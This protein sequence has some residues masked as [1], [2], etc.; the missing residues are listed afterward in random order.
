MTARSPDSLLTALGAGALAGASVGFIE[1][2]AGLI[3][4]G[5][6][7]GVPQISALV[8]E[9]PALGF[10]G[11]AMGTGLNLVARASRGL[12]P[13]FARIMFAAAL[14]LVPAI[15]LGWMGAP[16]GAA[17]VASAYWLWR[18]PDPHGLTILILWALLFIALH[19]LFGGAALRLVYTIPQQMTII[20][21]TMAAGGALAWLAVGGARP[22]SLALVFGAV[23]LTL[24][25]TWVS[26]IFLVR[27][28]G[29]STMEYVQM[30]VM[31]GM[32]SLMRHPAR[33]V[34]ET[35][36]RRGIR[37]VQWVILV[38]PALIIALSPFAG[39]GYASTRGFL[40]DHAPHGALL[41]RVAA[42]AYDR[43][44]DGYSPLFGFGDCDDGDPGLNPG[45]VDLPGD[46]IDQNCFAGDLT[47]VAH[48]YFNLPPW[49]TPPAA[50]RE[51]RRV[52]IMVIID[53][54]RADAVDY[55][56]GG[57]SRTPVLSEIAS[58]G[59]RYQNARAQSNNTGE[60]TPYFFQLGYRAL[61]VYDSRLAV[62][63]LLN[64]AGVC[65]A[66]LLQ[67]SVKE[68]WGTLGLEEVLFDFDHVERPESGIRSFPLPEMGRRAVALLDQCP[69]EQDALL[70]VHYESLH[71]T[72][73]H[74]ASAAPL[75]GGRRMD[76][77]AQL[78]ALA[79]P[80]RLAET[81]RAHYLRTVGAIDQS[82]RPLWERAREIEKDAGVMLIVTSDHGEEFFEHGGFFHM[83]S[84]HEEV[85]RIP[86]LVYGGGARPGIADEHVGAYHVPATLLG[87]FG[88]SGP[89]I[90]PLD[91]RAE[92]ARNAGV[93]AHYSWKYLMDRRSFMVM[94]GNLKLVYQQAENIKRLYDLA[95]D[96]HERR[97]LS[98]DPR[99][100]ARLHGLEEHLDR[101]IYYINYGDL[102]MKRKTRHP[103][104]A[105]P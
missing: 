16:V 12:G 8:W 86:L 70:M 77:A 92:R 55:A 44:G 80:A 66:G 28:W 95:T 85:L 17:G 59:I 100:A 82:L 31:A 64:R 6:T 32:V 69:P 10:L 45:A 62:A 14:T 3:S 29:F 89:M 103:R 72:F 71:D 20:I 57:A 7:V 74:L 39:N 93:F 61:P 104:A 73:A 51:R 81:M 38:A 25:L 30:V 22:A 21:I 54:L 11:A 2:T 90:E 24:A 9:I 4:S 102:A 53:T 58:R 105:I 18:R 94:E 1:W 84:L 68:W 99:Y 91:L 48:P 67:A 76:S 63:P 65:T 52:A 26:S 5:A 50:G 13:W 42:D 56:T 101:I 79:R 49:P 23:T 88:F 98:G 96:P 19:P 47:N 60:S 33:R 97:D 35:L 34:I 41:M 15:Q 37:G 87:F 36:A 27:L 78:L 43:D 75:E 46:G 40:M 83:G